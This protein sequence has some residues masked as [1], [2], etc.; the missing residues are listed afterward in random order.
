MYGHRSGNRVEGQ[1]TKYQRGGSLMK[2]A[3][4]QRGGSLMKMAKNDQNSKGGDFDEN[5]KK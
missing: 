5:G 1:M 2:M 4:Y 3:K